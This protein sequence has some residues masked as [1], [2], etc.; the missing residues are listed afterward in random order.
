MVNF[1]GSPVI[2]SLMGSLVVV[3]VK[4]LCWARGSGLVCR[5]VGEVGQAMP[6]GI[7]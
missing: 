4:V 1:V 3:E 6:D 7:Q 2:E 5:F